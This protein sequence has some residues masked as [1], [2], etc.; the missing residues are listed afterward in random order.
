[1]K[2]MYHHKVVEM[3]SR[4]STRTTRQLRHL[5]GSRMLLAVPT[6]VGGSG[7]SGLWEMVALNGKAEAYLA[8]VAVFGDGLGLDR[9]VVFTDLDGTQLKG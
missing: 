7:S 6:R 9:A 5:E 2:T 3:C 1:M 8:E 4:V